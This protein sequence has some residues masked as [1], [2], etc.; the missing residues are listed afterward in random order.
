MVPSATG[1]YGK[2][3]KYLIDDMQEAFEP[4]KAVPCIIITS[5]WLVGAAAWEE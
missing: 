2:N 4:L 1:T 5:I 3:N